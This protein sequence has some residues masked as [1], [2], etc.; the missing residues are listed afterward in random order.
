M[1][2]FVSSIS[3]PLPVENASFSQ[4]AK[5]EAFLFLRAILTNFDFKL[6]E[7]QVSTSGEVQ[8]LRGRGQHRLLKMSSKEVVCIV[9]LKV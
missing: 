4:L 1:L 9:Y 3:V 5:M 8:F 2:L 6:V 7:G